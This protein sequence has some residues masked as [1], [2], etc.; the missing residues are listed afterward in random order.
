M[1]NRCGKPFRLQERPAHLESMP[2]IGGEK[3]WPIL[4]VTPERRRQPTNVD[5]SQSFGSKIRSFIP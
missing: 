2:R 3:S 4:F 1:K 5:D